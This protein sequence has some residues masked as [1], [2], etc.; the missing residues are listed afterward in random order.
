MDNKE[1]DIYSSSECELVKISEA[2]R[3][4]LWE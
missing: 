3:P 2:R 4:V 1:G